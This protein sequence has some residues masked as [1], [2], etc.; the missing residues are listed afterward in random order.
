MKKLYIFRHAKSSWENPGLS[1]HE[2]TIIDKGARRTRRMLEYMLENGIRPERL[3]SST[4]VRAMQTAGII[5]EGFE[6]EPVSD[7]RLYEASASDY[8]EV[9]HSQPDEIS[10]LMLFGHNGSITTFG[11]F[12]L[13]QPIS[14]LPTSG[15]IGLEFELD[16]WSEIDRGKSPV[17]DLLLVPKAL[18]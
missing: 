8:F 7:S 11:N 13:S 17:S 4:A 18:K 3:V 2:R 16:S 1:D 15:M 12:F 9:I 5:G 10:S 14:W 6:L